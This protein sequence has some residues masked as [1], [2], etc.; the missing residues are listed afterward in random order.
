MAGSPSQSWIERVRLLAVIIGV[1]FKYQEEFRRF[2]DIFSIK[3]RD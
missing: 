1:V 3:T 2:Y